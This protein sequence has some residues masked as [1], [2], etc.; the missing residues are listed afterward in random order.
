MKIVVDRSRCVGAGM[1]ELTAGAVFE[2]DDNGDLTVLTEEVAAD[3]LT[4]VRTAV[5]GCP[6]AALRLTEH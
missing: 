3:Q 1:C 6:T 5:E 4:A 2:I